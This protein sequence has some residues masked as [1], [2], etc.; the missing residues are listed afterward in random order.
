MP[1]SPEAWRPQQRGRDTV[2]HRGVYGDFV[3]E[4]DWAVGEVTRTLDELGLTG[5]TLV[6]VTSDNSGRPTSD[7]GGHRPNGTLRGIK[8]QIWEGGHRIHLIVR[9]PG[10][11]E[12]GSTSDETV[13]LTD[14][15]STLAAYFEYDLPHAA[16]ED[17]VNILPVLRGEAYSQPI[18]EAT[19]HHSATGMFAIRQ[20]DWKLVEGD[21][22]GDY[23]EGHHG[24]AE[25]ANLPVR[26]PTTGKFQPF[27]YDILDCDQDNPIHRL[28]NLREDP[29]ESMDVAAQH[30]AK[31]SEL[32]GILERYR[33]SGRSVPER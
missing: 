22:D 8:R 6:A 27:T 29:G 9:W 7:M 33:R 4:F 1:N 24:A 18:R 11:V 3:V 20:G 32:I 17:S 26:D 10:E 25:A 31:V 21:T 30:P 19:V 2:A 15:M 14:L 23:R 28:F 13:C 5:N 12:A 16:A